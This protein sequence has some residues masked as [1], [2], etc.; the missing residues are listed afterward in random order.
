MKIQSWTMNNNSGCLIQKRSNEYGS[1]LEGNVATRYGFVYV[2]CEM[3]V[4]GF[5]F[6]C[7]GRSYYT[8][9]PKALTARGLT[10]IAGRFAKAVA[11]G[12]IA[13]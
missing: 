1:W 12:T 2:F 13:A 9:R 8:S 3:E 6:I 4:S 10:I 11:E 7:N 5:Q